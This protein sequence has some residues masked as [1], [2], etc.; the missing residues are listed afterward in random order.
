MLVVTPTELVRRLQPPP[1]A[2]PPEIT[3]A[4]HPTNPR[5]RS[6]YAAA[7]LGLI[8]LVSFLVLTFVDDPGF[9]ARARPPAPVEGLTIFAV[10][11]VGALAVERLLE[12]IAGILLP[13]AEKSA[14]VEEKASTAA[15][16]IAHAANAPS[17]GLDS[18]ATNDA[19]E[20]VRAAA[21]AK[22]ELTDLVWART[23]VYWALASGVGIFVS[24]AMKLYL[25]R[26]VGIGDADR[27][28]EVLA[29]G[30]I[31]GAGT[32]PLHDLTKLITAQK[33]AKQAAA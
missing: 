2:I 29:T 14:E 11:F 3:A 25:L 8:A 5:Q 16:K 6:V 4:I 18:V 13:K 9:T 27:W 10:F 28:L 31:I 19:N 12:P 33:E 21:K 30:L 1:A 22:S 24:A 26:T 32:K 17:A 7:S 20:A 23:V 15:G